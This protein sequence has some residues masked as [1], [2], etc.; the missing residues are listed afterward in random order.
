MS[1]VTRLHGGKPL[2]D[3]RLPSYWKVIFSLVVL[4]LTLTETLRRTCLV[5]LFDGVYSHAQFFSKLCTK[6]V[7]IAIDARC[8]LHG[9]QHGM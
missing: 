8:L 4:H 5:A 6:W 9:Y 7:F 3:G 2:W 1:F